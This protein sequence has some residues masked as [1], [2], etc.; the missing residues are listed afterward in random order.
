MSRHFIIRTL[1]VDGAAT[2]L[3]ATTTITKMHPSPIS[4]TL[5]I[6]PSPTYVASTPP[7]SKKWRPPYM[8]HPMANITDGR[9]QALSPWRGMIQE[10]MIIH[11]LRIIVYEIGD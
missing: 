8:A 11:I 4:S 3:A 9:I 6:Y 1:T 5:M 2:P 7:Y 10:G